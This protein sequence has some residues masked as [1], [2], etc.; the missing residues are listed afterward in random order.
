VTFRP[1]EPGYEI[2]KKINATGPAVLNWQQYKDIYAAKGV[3]K[4][5]EDY[6]KYQQ[7]AQKSQI[8]YEKQSMRQAGQENY[9]RSAGENPANV[10]MERTDYTPQQAAAV[11]PGTQMNVPMHKQ[12]VEF[13]KLSGPS[14]AQTSLP[15][16]KKVRGPEPSDPN[17]VYHATSRE[18]VWDIAEGGKL[19]THKPHEFTDQRVWP[20]GGAE[21]RNYFTSTADNTW[22]FAPEEGTPVLLRMK[23]DAHSTMAEKGTGDLYSTKPVLAEK[24]EYLG[25]DN[26][27]HPVKPKVD[28]EVQM[29]APLLRGKAADEAW[30]GVEREPKLNTTT[31][32]FSNVGGTPISTMDSP[33]IKG[34]KI[35]NP[36]T[37]DIEK[38]LANAELIFGAGDATGA[39]G[40]L[41]G[42]KNLPFEEPVGRH[43]GPGY[44]SNMLGKPIEG[45]PGASPVWASMKGPMGEILNIARDVE[46]RGKVPWLTYMT[47]GKQYLDSSMQM[48]DT[49]LQAAKSKGVSTTANEHLVKVMHS[50][51][52]TAANSKLPFPETG[53]KDEVALRA[54]I[55]ASPQPQRA[56]LVKAMDTKTARDLGF[57][58]I[59]ELRVWNT[60]PRMI[61]APPGS[62]GLTMS[63]VDPSIGTVKS[64]HPAY[65]TAVGGTDVATLGMQVPH[66]IIAPT[67]H[68]SRMATLKKPQYY[69]AAPHLYFPGGGTHATKTEPVTNEMKDRLQ[70]WMRKHPGGLA[71][72]G[73]A[74]AGGMGSLVDPSRYEAY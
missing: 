42:S 20:D 37:I 33:I 70:E 57:P 34:S 27:W 73:T 62:A 6:M 60:D 19:R 46:S 24:L 64:H 48:V 3:N 44:A 14:Q 4:T 49:A 10:V 43:G 65:D 69:E 28:P 41:H 13:N 53:L 12:T 31:H 1:G 8:E 11:Y 22:Q 35:I 9:N 52:N 68:A 72:A 30:R 7:S 36:R 5:P 2:Y 40:K 16:F 58:N 50:D 51:W 67:M 25:A 71:V 15:E 26:Q 32:P 61:T 54:W 63:R 29:S 74:G 17:Y 47:G 23:R 18:N 21:K 45:H 56:K 38:D 66:Q 55:E 59:G 39:G